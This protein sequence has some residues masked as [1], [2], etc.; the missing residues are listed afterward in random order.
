MA[1]SVT[2]A[3]GRVQPLYKGAYIAGTVYNKLDNVL[4][5]GGTYVSLVDNNTVNPSDTRYWQIIA[6]KG[7]DGPQ[8]VQGA[9]GSFG[10]PTAQAEMLNVGEQPVVVVTATGPDEAKI[11]NFDFGIP[12]SPEPIFKGNYQHGTT[13]NK[14][15]NVLYQGTTYISL[16]NGN[17]NNY[18]TDTS[19]WQVI[20]QRGATGAQGNTG[21]FGTPTA[22]ATIL[23]TGADPTVT[24][25]ASGPDYEKVFN[26]DFGIPA[27][28][29]GFDDISASAT[30]IGAGSPPTVSAN[31]T[32]E[33]DERILNFD[34]GI[35]AADGSGVQ[36]VDN[37]GADAN[38][39]VMLSAVRYVPQTLSENQKRIS[40]DNIGAMADPSG[41]EYGSFLC[42]GGSVS[43][44][45]WVA[46]QILQVPTGGTA[47]YVLRKQNNG[48][49]WTPAYEMPAGGDTGA[50]LVKNSKADYDF[51]WTG[52]IS[53]ENIDIIIDN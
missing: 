36:Y 30:S 52:T 38:N 51:G 10:K 13:Y 39:N 22:E 16:V 34:F 31:L 47:G 40:R 26:F 14:L 29:F 53:N 9:T 15:D 48:Y 7:N 6:Q 50:I 44:P 25:T 49:G 1:N 3:L 42:Y 17:R 5:N 18:P 19:Y 46:Q 23:E 4:F 20:A 33:D 27:G 11:F 41:K 35:P 43:D 8:G 12:S 45:S 37:I 28:P 21:S 32:V 24:I 2:T